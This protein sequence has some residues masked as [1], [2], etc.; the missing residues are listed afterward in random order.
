MCSS[1]LHI[2]N[3]QSILAIG[4][5]VHAEKPRAHY[6]SEATVVAIAPF[7]SSGYAAVPFALSGSCKAETGE[8]MGKWVTSLIRAWNDHPDGAAARGPIWSIATDGEPTMRMCRFALCMTH[9]L[10][11]VDPLHSSLKNLT[12]LNLRTGPDN[13]TMTC[14]PKHVIKRTSACCLT[15]CAN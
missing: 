6:A 15:N 4:E 12:G 2:L 13:M 7:Q 3:A 8:G 10:P 1:D 5:A 14:D 11:V 9:T